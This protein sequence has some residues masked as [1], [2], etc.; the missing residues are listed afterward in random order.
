MQ[1][2]QFH[3]IIEVMRAMI[4]GNDWLSN[5]GSFFFVMEG[6]GIKHRKLCEV[7]ANRANSYEVLCSKFDSVDFDT[8]MQR[9]ND[10]VLM[11]MDL[12]LSYHPQLYTPPST[13]GLISPTAFQITHVLQ[14]FCH[15]CAFGISITSMALMT[16]LGFIR[17]PFTI[18]ILWQTLVV[19][20][21]RCRQPGLL[22][23]SYAFNSAMAC[24]MNKSGGF[25][26]V[27]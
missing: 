9:E 7:N 3:H 24:I 18:P 2:N 27:K 13:L 10:Q 26:V 6:K 1:T 19:I 25:E 5:F 23:C 16:L 12:G 15:L 22:S 14:T 8:L 17:A 20:K 4:Q 21:Q 11:D